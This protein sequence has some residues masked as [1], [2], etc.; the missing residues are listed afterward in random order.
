LASLAVHIKHQTHGR[1]AA[2]K[3][4]D[5]EGSKCPSPARRTIV[6]QVHKLGSSE[7]C[8]N[9]RCS[10]DA[11]DDHS[12]LEGCD[13]CA[14]D[15]DNVQKANVT[16]PVQDVSSNVCL[17]VGASSLQDHA[18]DTDEQHQAEAFNATPDID[19]LCH[20]ERN[21]SSKSGGDDSSDGEQ[22]VRGES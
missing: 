6:K 22:T 2:C 17:Y 10:V 9:P 4:N 18:D 16:S 14:H 19:R 5:D 21:A 15:I 20:G 8:S 1:N 12:V 7:R 3:K 13:V 11:K